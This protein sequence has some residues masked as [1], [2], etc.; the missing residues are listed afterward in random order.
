[1]ISDRK[2]VKANRGMVDIN[3]GGIPTDELEAL[4]RACWKTKDDK[5]KALYTRLLKSGL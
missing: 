4:L 3:M 2:E 1:M 5:L